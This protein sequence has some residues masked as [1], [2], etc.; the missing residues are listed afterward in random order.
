MH[1]GIDFDN[2]IVCYDGLFHRVCREKDLVPPEVPV[3]KS[4]VRN[5]LRQV[6]REDDWTEIQG[7]VYGARMAG[8]DP[9]PG[10]HDFFCACRNAGVKVS[11][12]SHKTREPYRG[13]A[14]DLHRAAREWLELQGFFDGAR[15]GLP[16]DQVY[17]ELTKQDKLERI[18]ACGC[19]H[20]IDDLPEFLQE[21]AF[22]S[23]VQRLLFD[24]ND[25]YVSGKA[26]LRFKTWVE[27]RA[28]FRI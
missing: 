19:T 10:M 16:R 21:P 13:Q 17:L 26:Y 1:I 12:I 20:F 18:G 28:W 7:Y 11:I 24:P 14:Y 2:T 4:E 27:I 9:F 5:Y 15:L 22:P 23:G 3:S 6:G 25:H 8:A